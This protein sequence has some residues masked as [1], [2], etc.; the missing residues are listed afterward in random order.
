M[1]NNVRAPRRP[2]SK[3]IKSVNLN[4]VGTT[5]SQLVIHTVSA[6]ETLIRIVGNISCVAGGNPGNYIFALVR[7]R[8][9]YSAL[10]L[11]LGSGNETYDA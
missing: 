1:S 9:G 2:I 5:Q 3:I 10:N 8:D 6:A 7:L 4:A 11:D